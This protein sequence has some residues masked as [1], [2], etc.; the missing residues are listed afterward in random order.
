MN[1]STS[2]SKQP[3]KKSLAQKE[4]AAA[5]ETLRENIRPGDKVWTVTRRAVNVYALF[6]GLTNPT[7]HNS[8]VEAAD[9]LYSLHTRRTVSAGGSK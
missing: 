1:E 5:L 3:T 2:T 6:H 4:R 7:V 8:I 9:H